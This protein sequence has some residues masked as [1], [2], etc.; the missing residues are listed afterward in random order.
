[1]M[2]WFEKRMDL[3]SIMRLLLATVSLMAVSLIGASSVFAAMPPHQTTSTH[4]AA[5]GHQAHKAM[6]THK[7][8]YEKSQ[9]SYVLPETLLIDASA[10]QHALSTLLSS[11]SP[12]LLNFIFTSCTTICPILSATFSQAQ[13]DLMKKKHSPRMISISIDPEYD[14]P[15]RLTDYAKKFNAGPNWSFYTG[16]LD[17]IVALQRA[18]DIFRGN[19][20][21]HI[22][23]V[24]MR[25]EKEQPWSRFD[26]FLSKANLLIEYQHLVDQ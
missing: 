13:A 12:I 24:F 1:V 11:D 22:P 6:M 4:Q 21:N 26:G 7:A 15:T 3:Q 25:A 2:M 16:K 10:K 9:V 14:T 18:F 5:D 19:K 8:R 20:M 23:V 17:D